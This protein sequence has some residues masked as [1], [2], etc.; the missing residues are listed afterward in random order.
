MNTPA[1]LIMGAAVFGKPQ[2]HRLTLAALIGATIPDASLYALAG[3]ELFVK[4][5]PGDVVF[6][7]L[8]FSD[9]WQ[10][11]FA[12]DN[13]LV[14]WGVALTLA[15]W[16]RSGVA[17]AL[18]GAAI[19]HIAI[20]LPLHADDARMHFWPI[21]D[22]KFFSPVSYWDSSAGGRIFGVFEVLL[23]A[24]MTT[25]LVWRWKSW[26]WRAAF[27]ALAA[28]QVVPFFAWYLFF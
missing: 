17:I 21:T 18:C 8:Y 2:Q 25:Y 13:S 5:T 6:G 9:A 19:L 15:I 3:W 16:L 26:P 4:G 27:L 20:D 23:V 22:W 28:M 11:I 12:I 10:R 24:A 7:Q 1:H 14:L